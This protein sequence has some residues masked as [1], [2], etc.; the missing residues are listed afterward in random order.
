[1]NNEKVV[2]ITSQGQLTIPK[3]ILKKFGISKG[4]KA[5][6]WQSGKTIMVKPKKDFWQL[7][8]SLA[9]KIKL[10]DAQLR[11]ARETFAKK[12]PRPLPK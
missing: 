11:K 9:G 4:A 3:P 8:G 1:M 6:I 12:W 10:T 5:I 2:S 7:G